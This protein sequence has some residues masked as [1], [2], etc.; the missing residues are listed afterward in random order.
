MTSEICHNF[1]AHLPSLSQRN[2]S[3]PLSRSPPSH[4]FDLISKCPST[5]PSRKRSKVTPTFS[6]SST[7]SWSRMINRTANY[8]IYALSSNHFKRLSPE[9]PFLGNI[10]SSSIHDQLLLHETVQP[11]LASLRSPFFLTLLLL[12]LFSLLFLRWPV[13]AEC[14]IYV[15]NLRGS[16]NRKF[17]PLSL[18]WNCSE[19]WTTSVTTISSVSTI[20][21]P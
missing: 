11:F 21:P 2:S 3:F 18:S 15:K 14:A 16:S 12:G 19:W 7:F 4:F 20:I 13:S 17:I 9:V 8:V 1:T 10:A 6:S 5:S